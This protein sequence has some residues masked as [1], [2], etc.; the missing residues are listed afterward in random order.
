MSWTYP[1]LTAFWPPQCPYVVKS[2]DNLRTHAHDGS[3]LSS[4]HR[5]FLVLLE[6]FGTSHV[7][8]FILWRVHWTSWMWKP[9]IF[10]HVLFFSHV[11]SNPLLDS[12]SSFHLVFPVHIQVH[13]ELHRSLGLCAIPAMPDSFAYLSRTLHFL[14]SLTALHRSAALCAHPG[15]PDGFA[16]VSRALCILWYAWDGFAQ[17][18]G[19]LCT[20]WYA[21]QLCA[22]LQSYFRFPS[23]I[24][25]DQSCFGSPGKRFSFQ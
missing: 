21:W 11:S 5:E 18:S 13:R 19:A 7:D 10:H 4:Y 17:V 14:L 8:V 1:C 20:S 16:Q 9:S 12:F 23:L 2:V 3:C 24:F 22:S 6:G 25:A 15:M